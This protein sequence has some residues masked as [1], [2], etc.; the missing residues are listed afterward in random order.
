MVAAA[1]LLVAAE[2]AEDPLDVVECVAVV[3]VR[4]FWANQA[5]AVELVAVAAVAVAVAAAVAAA[6]RVAAAVPRAA[7]M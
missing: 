5:V 6:E 3:V 1:V 4:F 2:C 7:R